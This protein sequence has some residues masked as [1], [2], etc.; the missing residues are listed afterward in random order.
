VLKTCYFNH[1]FWGLLKKTHYIESLTYAPKLF[2]I[3]GHFSVKKLFSKKVVTFSP[4]FTGISPVFAGI[5][6][7]GHM[8]PTGP[9]PAGPDR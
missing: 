5:S 2:H 6:P 8:I 9:F 3:W 7:F 4:V 1:L